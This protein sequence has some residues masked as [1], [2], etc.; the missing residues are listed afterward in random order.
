MKAHVCCDHFKDSDFIIYH[1]SRKL[2]KEAYPTVFNGV[3][4]LFRSHSITF[5]KLSD[6]FYTLIKYRNFNQAKTEKTLLTFIW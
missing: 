3:S 5:N 1:N 2:K 4:E 6:S